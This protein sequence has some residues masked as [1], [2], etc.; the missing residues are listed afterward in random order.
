MTDIQVRIAIGNPNEINT[1]SSRHGISE[2]WIYYNQKGMQTY[3]QF[4][5]GRLVFIGK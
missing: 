4:E 2:Q 5:Y 3:Y 1:T